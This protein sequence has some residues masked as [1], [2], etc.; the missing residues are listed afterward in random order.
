MFV[1]FS[2]EGGRLWATEILRSSQQREPVLI[3]MPFFCQARLAKWA[4]TDSDEEVKVIFGLGFDVPPFPDNCLP[5]LL[6]HK[7]PGLGHVFP[8][9]VSCKH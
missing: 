3:T 1:P 2:A 4:L 6:T 9:S 7:V 8:Q 5:Q